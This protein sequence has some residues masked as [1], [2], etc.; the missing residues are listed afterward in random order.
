MRSARINTAVSFSLLLC[1]SLWVP[2]QLSGQT[3]AIIDRSFEN[4]S[5]QDALIKI[6]SEFGLKFYLFADSIPD[7]N[8]TLPGDSARLSEALNLNFSP[9]SIHASMDRHGNVFL[10]ENATVYTTL[11]ADYFNALN[12]E[13]PPREKELAQNEYLNTNKVYIPKTIIVGNRKAGLNKANA[14]VDGKVINSED[15]SPII[16][17]TIYVEE[18]ENGTV[19]NENGQFS[20]ELKK[21]TYTFRVNSIEST[22]KIV[23]VIVYS[24]GFLNI[25]L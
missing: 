15:L 7:F 22:E 18:T 12:P 11:S 16:N 3:D 23:K 13:P 19:T 24:D 2:V 4:M 5:W 14:S 8:F 21:G 1:L 20:I 6:E 10:V 9:F 25:E 17:G